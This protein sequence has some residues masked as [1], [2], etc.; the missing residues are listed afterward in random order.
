MVEVDV[1]PV[2]YKTTDSTGAF[3][4][5]LFLGR[6]EEGGTR[7]RVDRPDWSSQTL[8]YSTYGCGCTVLC[9]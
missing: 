1:P 7:G 6:S 8:D 5:L 4:R 3:L 2:W 9:T